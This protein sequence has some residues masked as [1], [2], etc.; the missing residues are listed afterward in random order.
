MAFLNNIWA[1]LSEL[2]FWLLFGCFIAGILHVLISRNWLNKHLGGSGFF[3]VVKAVFVGVPMPLCSCGVIP[4]ALGLKKQGAGAGASMGFLISTPQTGVDS[5]FVS[6][7]MLSWPFAIFKL[8]S[9][10]ILGLIGG[11][12]SN[13]IS[14]KEVEEEVAVEKEDVHSNKLFAIYDFAINDLLYMIWR[15]IVIGV[16]VSATI[17]TWL[18]AEAFSDWTSQSL[19]FVLLGVLVISLPL[20]VCATSSVPIAAALVDAGMPLSAALVFLMAGPATNMATIGA[21]YK[22]FGLKHLLNYLLTI[23]VG[24]LLL[25]YCFDFLLPNEGLGVMHHHESE[26]YASYILLFFFATFLFRDLKGVLNQSSSVSEGALESYVF[27]VDGLTCQGCVKKLT[28]AFSG[29]PGV[30]NVDVNLENG[31]VEM[32]AEKDQKKKI[33]EIVEKTGFRFKDFIN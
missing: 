33:I 26:S 22:G 3:S 32:T 8:L 16:L 12:V 7:S 19:I 30:G 13:M 31:K 15:W 23:I 29:L 27:T 24:S 17:S 14:S 11:G 1:V 10:F 5:I 20:Y 28:S 2:S 9:A 18:P 25:A 4:A 21:V 6:A